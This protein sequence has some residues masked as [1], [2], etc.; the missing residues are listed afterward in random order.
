MFLL[1]VCERGGISYGKYIQGLT[2]LS[3]GIFGDLL[4][5]LS[6]MSNFLIQESS[7]HSNNLTAYKLIKYRV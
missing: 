3:N 7:T 2:F 5:S 4:E 6:H 1:M